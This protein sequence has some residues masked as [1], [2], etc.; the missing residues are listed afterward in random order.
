M[1]YLFRAKSFP[2]VIFFSAIASWG[3][4][5]QAKQP[6][7]LRVTVVDEK[8]CVVEETRILCV[9][10]LK[11]LREVVKLPAGSM[12]RVRVEDTATTATDEA[13]MKVVELL[14]NSEYNTPIGIVDVSQAPDE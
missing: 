4:P 8:S 2:L 7:K 13:T 12:V 9:E 14:L 1:R 3:L 10:L 5:S 11:H 6:Q